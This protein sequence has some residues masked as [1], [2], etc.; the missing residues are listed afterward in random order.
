MFCSN[1]FHVSIINYIFL[2]LHCFIFLQFIQFITKFVIFD[3]LIKLFFCFLDSLSALL[4]SYS[5]SF[6]RFSLLEIILLHCFG[7][8]LNDFLLQFPSFLF[9]FAGHIIILIPFSLRTPFIDT[10]TLMLFVLKLS[11][12]ML[13]FAP[14]ALPLIFL[15]IAPSPMIAPLAQK[16]MSQVILPQGLTSLTHNFIDYGNMS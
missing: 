1:H 4:F 9:D 3:G 10:M 7:D 11:F 5:G 6:V 2:F 14:W 12:G 16:H 13:F 15:I 8:T